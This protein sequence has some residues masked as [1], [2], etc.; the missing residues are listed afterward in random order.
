MVLVG[1]G[2]K[3]VVKVGEGGLGLGEF[4][5]VWVV[6]VVSLLVIGLDELGLLGIVL[7]WKIVGIEK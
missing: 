1:L 3:V 5:I 6:M 2:L 4:I 7:E